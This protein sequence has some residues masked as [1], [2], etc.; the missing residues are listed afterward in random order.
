MQ[1]GQPILDPAAHLVVAQPEASL[2]RFAPATLLSA[3]V[4][5][6]VEATQSLPIANTQTGNVFKDRF[7]TDMAWYLPAFQLA[8]DVDGAFAFTATQAGV[9]ESGNPF[10]RVTLAVGVA[11]VM[12]ADVNAYKQQNPSVQLRE[13][14]LSALQPTL[15]TTSQDT[16]TGASKQSTYPGTVAPAADGSLRLTFNT[17]LGVGAIVAYENL[18]S[19]GASIGL[20]AS[21]D[22]WRESTV[23]MPPR[24]IWLQPRSIV[25][26][27]ELPVRPPGA[28][29]PGQPVTVGRPV[30]VWEPDPVP[31]HSGDQSP[32]Y[33][34]SVASFAA[35][36]PL[37]DKYAGVGYATRYTISDGSVTRAITGINDLKN[38]NTRQSEFS[39]FTAL[40]DI[41]QRYPS[42]DRL[43]IGA[44]SRTIV[45]LPARYGVVRSADGTAAVCQALLDS[46][47]AG[48]G[49]CKFQFDFL[50]GPVISP[51]E[52]V[53]L[54]NEIAANPASHDCTVVLPAKLDAGQTSTLATAFQTSVSYGTGGPAHTFSLTVGVVD[55]PGTMPA[56]ATANLFIK[57]LTAQVEPYLTG[58]IGIKLDDAY[59]H[60]VDAGVVL[61]FSVT[62]GSNEIAFTVGAGGT[63]VVLTNTSPLDLNLTRYALIV[64][65]QVSVSPFPEKLP[66]KQTVSLPATGAS[67]SAQ[68]L[69]D[70]ALAL[71]SPLTKA[72]TTRYL[73][74][75]VQDVQNV[76]YE[77]GIVAPAVDFK[78]LGIAKID[79]HITL[80]DLPNIAV[81][82]FSLIDL[83]RSGNVT[84]SL[85]IQYAISS[86]AATIAF[87]VQPA[88]Q[89]Q[90]SVQFTLAHDF[91]DQPI[92]ILDGANIPSFPPPAA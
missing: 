33:V 17:I 70:R 71:E 6:L 86:L 29:R 35:T 54:S 72:A 61:N 57:Q 92:L 58:R 3:S 7:A 41:S 26:D 45:A 80:T 76:Q 37:G 1:P 59:E 63:S 44:L 13:I 52:L 21:Y 19:G 43:Y 11:K 77:L 74:L 32:S 69:V 81:P 14:P 89:Q 20:S 78:K 36:L 64:N 60:P 22:V 68:L 47:A 25:P 66:A 73:T 8:A 24:P 51:I 34:Q 87:A 16:Q 91:I 18:Q 30:R 84:I 46:S 79:V 62:S 40:G 48:G 42:F 5:R 2:V 38:F 28:F 67:E 83:D 55:A 75:V 27:E 82:S 88:N 56:V 50:L 49:A 90:T 15:T 10:N 4:G 39:E 65:N 9:D 85:P 53:E 12:P 31:V 23:R